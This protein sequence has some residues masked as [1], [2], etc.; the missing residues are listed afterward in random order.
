MMIKN[1]ALR[2]AKKM[3]MPEISLTEASKHHP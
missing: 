3:K 2:E 1:Q